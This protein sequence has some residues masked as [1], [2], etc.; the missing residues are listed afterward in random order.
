MSAGAS[1]RSVPR[2]AVGRGKMRAQGAAA[3]RGTRKSARNGRAIR[4]ESINLNPDKRIDFAPPAPMLVTVAAEFGVS[5]DVCRVG[6]DPIS[7]SARVQ[8]LADELATG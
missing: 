7:I 3:E 5:V 1:N 4:S 2:R 8:G 6:G